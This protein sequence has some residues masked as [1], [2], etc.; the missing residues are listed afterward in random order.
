VFI[1]Y[2]ATAALADEMAST[3]VGARAQDVVQ[4]DRLS[5]AIELYLGTRR[6]LTLSADSRVEGLRLS[7]SKARRGE[8]APSPLALALAARI[9]GSRLSAVTQPP[10]ERCLIFTFTGGAGSDGPDSVAARLIAE[11]MG[12]LANL[13]LIDAGGVIL[14]AAHPVTAAMSRARLVLPGQPY[15][16]P[17]VPPKILPEQVTAAEI[18]AWTADQAH[19]PAWQVL[20]RQVRGASPLAAREVIARAAG[21][22]QTAAGSV[23]P[24]A[25]AAALAALFDLPST[26]AWAPS[27]AVEAA[28]PAAVMA[29]A[30]Y[31]LTQYR[32]TGLGEVTRVPTITAAIEAFE[33]A[34]QGGDAYQTARAG[35]LALIAEAQARA[36]RKLASLERETVDEAAIEPLRMA[37]DMIL[38]F[39]FQIAPRQTVLDVPLELDVPLR[40]DLDPAL[41]PVDNAQ[42]YY[43][44][45]RRA[46]RAAEKLPERIADVQAQ[47]DT[48]DQL[49]TDLALA[50][51]RPAID[52][53]HED[54]RATGLVG[55]PLRRRVAGGQVAAQPL[56]IMS[57]DGLVILVGRN[58][59][60]NERVTFDRAARGDRWLHAAGVPGAHVV[61]KSAGRPVP[62]RTILEAAGLAAWFSRARGSTRVDVLVTDVRHVRRL[63]GGG[64]G[65]VT[66]DQGHVATV[67]VAPQGPEAVGER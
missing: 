41:S 57:A 44:R 35:V 58:S 50:E 3:L 22:P 62:E 24:G 7:E 27:I 66:I 46:R 17:P 38:A 53:V 9:E 67:T 18:A 36:R 40:I 54:L 5:V 20:V 25:V 63:R 29:Y 6:Y 59:R 34:R 45:Y 61:I 23:A 60:Q 26:R 42:R 51:N 55:R 12:R 48:L 43:K 8:D 15:Q 19:A 31:E 14:A 4:L 37:G 64:P 21:D 2:L 13:I 30:P 65:M 28:D 47:I 10:Y 56:S 32:R 49:E 1:D 11:L 52:G 16:A 39:Q 33:T